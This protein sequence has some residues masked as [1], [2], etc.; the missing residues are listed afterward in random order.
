M[1]S[2][3]PTIDNSLDD[4]FGSSPPHE[5]S[6]ASAVKALNVQSVFGTLEE[7]GEDEEGKPSPE[8]QLA[9]KGDRVVS[10][11]EDRVLVAHWE[12]NMDTLQMKEDGVGKGE[13]QSQG[14]V[15][16]SRS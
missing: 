13:S 7:G 11:W 15:A 3:G 14:V 16:G 1:T 12:E 2:P 4:I 6:R 9:G 10:K 5:P 8:T